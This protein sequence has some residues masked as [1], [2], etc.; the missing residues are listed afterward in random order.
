MSIETQTT[1]IISLSLSL[2]ENGIFLSEKLLLVWFVLWALIVLTWSG[3]YKIFWRWWKWAEKVVA[4][5]G[6]S[7]EPPRKYLFRHVDLSVT[8]RIIPLPLPQ[9]WLISLSSLMNLLYHLCFCF[10]LCFFA[11]RF[12][13][14]MRAR[15]KIRQRA[16]L[17]RRWWRRPPLLPILILLPLLIRCLF[18]LFFVFSKL[19][20]T[21]LISSQNPKLLFGVFNFKSRN[22]VMMRSLNF[23]LFSN[24]LAIDLDLFKCVLNEVMTI[25]SQTLFEIRYFFRI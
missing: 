13:R 19:F 14:I 5:P 12:H 24:L 7:G 8:D 3:G 25:K 21:L 10:D 2:W 4:L 17:V 11:D 9:L 18:L 6:N 23:P 22:L 15:R 16:F 20:I 1:S